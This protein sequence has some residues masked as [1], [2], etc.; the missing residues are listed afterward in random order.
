MV[1]NQDVSG[2]SL[3]FLS[4][5]GFWAYQ[6]GRG[7]FTW[8]LWFW[9]LGKAASWNGRCKKP[10]FPVPSLLLPPLHA[11]S[12]VLYEAVSISLTLVFIFLINKA[13]GVWAIWSLRNLAALTL[14]LITPWFPGSSW[15]F[16]L[17]L[18][19]FWLTNVLPSI[20]QEIECLVFILSLLGTLLNPPD[21]GL[22]G[23]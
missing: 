2:L 14:I 16:L 20:W 18:L 21:G 3:I 23:L 5:R 13:G 10:W 15:T 17:C 6:C 1:Q 11:H 7:S 19:W 12:K 8:G 4:S 22:V 9:T